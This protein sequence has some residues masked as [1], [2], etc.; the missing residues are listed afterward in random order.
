[1]PNYGDSNYWD[2][3]YRAQKNTTFDWLEGWDDLKE[4]IEKYSIEG[5]YK[6]EKAIN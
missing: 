1:M 4:I 6:D 2:E 5:L 3:R